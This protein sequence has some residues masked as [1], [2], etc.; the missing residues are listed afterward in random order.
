MTY[1]RTL[2]EGASVCVW[3]GGIKSFWIYQFG[4]VV[5]FVVFSDRLSPF[6]LLIQTFR[7][8][9]SSGP[10]AQRRS[11]EMERDGGVRGRFRELERDRERERLGERLA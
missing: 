11:R 3:G 6:P 8:Q 4:I 2:A 1:G 10:G 7:H 9:M 5:V